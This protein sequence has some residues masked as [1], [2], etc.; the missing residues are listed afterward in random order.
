[1]SNVLT[2]NGTGARSALAG[3]RPAAGKTGTSDG[4][5]ETWFVG[6]TPQLTTAVWV[7]T[8]LDNSTAA[9]QH[10]PAGR[11]YPVVFGA[12]IAAPTWKAIMD[13]ALAGQP[14]AD[15]PAPSDKIVNG[16][17]VDLR[18]CRGQTVDDA[19]SYLQAQGFTVNVGRRVYSN[20][21]PGLVAY[22]N[23]PDGQV[24]RGGTVTLYISAGPAPQRQPQPH[25]QQPA[26]PADPGNGNGDGN[27]NGNG[28]NGD[29]NGNGG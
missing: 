5:N 28:N 22:T 19:T 18:R 14:N 2:G 15:F 25:Q 26:A 1:M 11:P 21:R 23:P 4:N 7:G 10:R 8:P 13:R 6:Y 16:D 3:G 17:R 29:G 20:Y 27:G 12:S 9:R 24:N